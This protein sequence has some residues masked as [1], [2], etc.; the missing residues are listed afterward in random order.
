M[1]PGIIKTHKEALEW[2]REIEMFCL[3][4]VINVLLIYYETAEDVLEK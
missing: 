3:K 4:E 1:T 2:I